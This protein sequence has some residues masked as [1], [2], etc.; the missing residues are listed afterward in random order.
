MQQVHAIVIGRVQGVGF[1]AATTRLARQM[2]LRGWV[3]NL[4]D[5]SVEV[6]AVGSDKQLRDFVIWLNQGP[7]G[8]YVSQVDVDWRDLA[9]D[10]EGFNIRYA[11]DS[12]YGY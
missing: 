6:V 10:F 2:E 7:P 12:D 3:R 4:P 5:G 9:E 1:R 11:G 8:A